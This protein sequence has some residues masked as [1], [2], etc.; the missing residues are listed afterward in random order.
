MKKSFDRYEVLDAKETRGKTKECLVCLFLIFISIFILVLVIFGF[1]LGVIFVIFQKG[2]CE[3]FGMKNIEIVKH[4]I[5][6]NNMTEL[7]LSASSDI[8]IHDSLNETVTIVF[9]EFSLVSDH[10]STK[11]S[12]IIV[13]GTVVSVVATEEFH[14]EDMFMG[15]LCSGTSVDVYIPSGVVLKHLANISVVSNYGSVYYRANSTRNL[16]SL[17]IKADREVFL[18]NVRVSDELRVST[19]FWDS[20]VQNV[21]VGSRAFVSLNNVLGN[22]YIVGIKTNPTSESWANF[23][24]RNKYGFIDIM[25]L[26]RCDLVAETLYNGGVWVDFFERNLGSDSI[27]FSLRNDPRTSE[28]VAIE[29]EETKQ[30]ATITKR[31]FSNFRTLSINGTIYTTTTLKPVHSF[32]LRSKFG[33][34][35]MYMSLDPTESQRKTLE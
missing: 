21:E 10:M 31:E 34:I 14:W 18:G 33:G 6:L 17:K 24:V 1:L 22:M 29:S 7:H 27:A 25:D 23:E 3:F 15:S 20:Y 2:N 28:G 4:T 26:E 5:E 32:D 19:F 9:N 8:R 30:R 13:N 11:S 16:F 35:Y 12:R